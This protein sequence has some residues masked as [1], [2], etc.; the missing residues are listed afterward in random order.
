MLF[1]Y[2]IEDPKSFEKMKDI[3]ENVVATLGE[4]VHIP[5]GVVAAKSDMMQKK[6]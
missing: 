1:V 4:G 5:V 3:Y 6:K 2:N